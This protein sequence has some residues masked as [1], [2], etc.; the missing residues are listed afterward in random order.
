MR[1]AVVQYKYKYDRKVSMS[2]LNTSCRADKLVLLSLREGAENR[3]ALRGR[4]CGEGMFVLAKRA[5]ISIC[6]MLIFAPRVG[7][8]SYSC[9]RYCPMYMISALLALD[10]QEAGNITRRT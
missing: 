8:I 1:K 9:F 4:N 7:R 10:R 3:A 6:G 2:I 5:R